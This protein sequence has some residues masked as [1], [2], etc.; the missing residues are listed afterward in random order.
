LR[1]QPA[2]PFSY[3]PLGM[4]A[5][6]GRHN[7][8]ADIMGLKLS[9][10]PAWFLWR[11]LYLAKLPTLR[12]KIEVA[13]DWAWQLL[14]PPNIVQLQLARTNR[15]GRA[16][17]AAGEFVYHKGQPSD[18]FY[19]VESGTAGVYLD[20]NAPPVVVLKPGDHF[21]EGAL[22]SAEAAGVHAVSV[23][24]ET[25]L[26]LMTLGRD[27]FKRLSE[28]LLVLRREIEQSLTSRSAG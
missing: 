24:A 18:Q 26:D 7:A 1:N 8:V 20:E 9:G 10:F 27:D 12:R 25:P 13:I 23:K 14:F 2:R 22:L 3:R 21:G 19:V 11:G 17:Y 6:L 16:H 28:T 15:V 4:L 5:S